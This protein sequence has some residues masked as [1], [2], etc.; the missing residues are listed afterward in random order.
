MADEADKNLPMHD[1]IDYTQAL[2]QFMIKTFNDCHNIDLYE[3]DVLQFEDSF[4]YSE[5]DGEYKKEL[6]EIQKEYEKRLR[7]SFDNKTQ[8][9]IPH[10][11]EH[12]RGYVAH[13]R[14]RALIRSARRKGL[15]P[16]ESVSHIL[17]EE[18]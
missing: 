16:E 3:E 11:M 1:K 9:I 12:T 2:F 8:K 13:A 15:L 6:N 7:T 18:L 5:N 17:G 10:Q 4:P 14:Y